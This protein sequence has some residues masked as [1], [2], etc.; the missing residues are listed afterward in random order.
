MLTCVSLEDDVLWW[1]IVAMAIFA[2]NRRHSDAHMVRIQGDYN[3]QFYNRAKRR[4]K[5]T[6]TH[7]HDAYRDRWKYNEV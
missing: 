3:L 1:T 6:D 5:Y 7:R 4:K 2:R